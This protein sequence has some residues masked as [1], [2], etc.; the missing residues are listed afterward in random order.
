MANLTEQQLIALFTAISAEVM[1]TQGEPQGSN[2]IES[3]FAAVEDITK[4]VL[5]EVCQEI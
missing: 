5:V 2:E 4:N 3:F 1:N